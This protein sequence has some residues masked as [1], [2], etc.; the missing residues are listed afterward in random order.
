[1]MKSLIPE[2]CY[3]S[4]ICFERMYVSIQL[5]KRSSQRRI[6]KLCPTEFNLGVMKLFR[7]RM[8]LGQLHFPWW[9]SGFCYYVKQCK[10]VSM[11]PCLHFCAVSYSIRTC[12]CPFIGLCRCTVHSQYTVS[13]ER[14]KRHRWMRLCWEQSHRCPILL[15]KGMSMTFLLN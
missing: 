4:T 11:P 2:Q 6:L 14:W 5:R 15:H 7:Q 3:F 12:I 1:M 8:V 13:F 9:V 10:A